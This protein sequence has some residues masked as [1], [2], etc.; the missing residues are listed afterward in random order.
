MRIPAGNVVGEVND[1]WKVA[2]TTLSNERV[3]I[4]GGSGISDPDRILA[5]ARERGLSD[6]PIFRQ[7]FVSMWT[8]NEIIRLVR[9]RMVR[10]TLRNTTSLIPFLIGAVAGAVV[11]RRLTT[12]LGAAVVRDVAEAR[13]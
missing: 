3:T 5:L 7:K 6:D 4:A 11:N 10:R 2:V 9:R 1:G 12:S 13:S 8:R